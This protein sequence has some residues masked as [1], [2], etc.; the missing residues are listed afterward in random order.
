MHLGLKTDRRECQ[1]KSGQPA[2]DRRWGYALLLIRRLGNLF[3]CVFADNNL[4][5][6]SQPKEWDRRGGKVH[7]RD[8]SLNKLAEEGPAVE[9]GIGRSESLNLFF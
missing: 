5:L 6:S 8:G 3:L 4:L 7:P 2:F 1:E 9:D